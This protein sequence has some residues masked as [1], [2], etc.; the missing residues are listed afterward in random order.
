[1]WYISLEMTRPGLG[2]RSLCNQMKISNRHLQEGRWKEYE[3]EILEFQKHKRKYTL[4]FDDLLGK[5]VNEVNDLVEDAVQKPEVIFVDYIQAARTNS[6]EDDRLVINEYLRRFR[7]LCL[8]N[9]IVGVVVSQINRRAETV[10]ENRPTM[11]MLKGSGVLEEHAETVILLNYDFKYTNNPGDFNKF[12]INV[13]KQR[14]GA[15]FLHQCQYHPQF[16]LF[17][18]NGINILKQPEE[19]ISMDEAERRYGA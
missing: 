18:E 11:G 7:Q 9:K 12:E 19:H 4:I 5:T 1:V 14:D 16:C 13:A 2:E 8:R 3:K 17:A 15:T 10:R 6:H